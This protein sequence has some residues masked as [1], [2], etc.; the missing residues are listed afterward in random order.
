MERRAIAWKTMDA[1]VGDA[2][3]EIG[4]EWMWLA[5]ITYND[6]QQYHGLQ[7]MANTI[8]QRIHASGSGDHFDGMA[9]IQESAEQDINTVAKVRNARR[10]GEGRPRGLPDVQPEHPEGK[11]RSAPDL[12]EAQGQAR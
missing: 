9:S 6:W 8:K 2:Q 12:K 11:G 5:D 1:V 10:P 4:N 3:I 7:D